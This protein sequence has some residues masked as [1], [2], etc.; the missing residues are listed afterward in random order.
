MIINTD[1]NLLAVNVDIMAHQVNCM[2]VMGAGI[3]AQIAKKHP[4]VKEAYI[5][6]CEGK[7]PR[8]LL[9]D[10]QMVPIEDDRYVANVFGQLK[11]GRGK[12]HTNYKALE[13]ALYKLKENAQQND[14]TVGLPHGMGCGLAGGD[15]NIVVGLI[16]KVFDDYPVVVVK[17][18]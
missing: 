9:G 13:A 3:A 15:W 18:G 16:E 6:Y 1:G 8:E 7:D 5:R 17:L 10:C 12:Q 14:L 4:E 2:G 11:Y